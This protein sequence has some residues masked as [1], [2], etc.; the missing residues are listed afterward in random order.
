MTCISVMSALASNAAC[1]RRCISVISGPLRSL[2]LHRRAPI[3]TGAPRP[4][5]RP[6]PAVVPPLARRP[7]PRPP[8]C[9]PSLL[10]PCPPSRPPARP[11]PLRPVPS[12][13]PRPFLPLPARLGLDMSVKTKKRKTSGAPRRHAVGRDMAKPSDDAEDA[14]AEMRRADVRDFDL[15]P[16][17]AGHDARLRSDAPYRV[18]KALLHRPQAEAGPSRPSLPPIAGGQAAQS[19]AGR[20]LPPQCQARVFVVARPLDDSHERTPLFFPSSRDPTP[21]SYPGSRGPTPYSYFNDFPAR[22]TPRPTPGPA[23]SPVRRPA[24]PPRQENYPP[25]P[26]APPPADTRSPERKRRRMEG[27]DTQPTDVAQFLDLHA[28]DSD[29][30]DNEEAPFVMTQQ[31]L[32]QYPESVPL[33]SKRTLEQ[34]EVGDLEELAAHYEKE[35]SSYT[36]SAAMELDDV[37]ELSD[38]AHDLAQHPGLRPAMEEAISFVMPKPAVPALP[39]R[40]EETAGQ[41]IHRLKQLVLVQLPQGFQIVATGKPL[42]QAAYP[43]IYPTIEEVAPFFVV[44]D[45]FTNALFVG[46]A[47]CLQAGDRVIVTEGQRAGDHFYI[48]KVRDFLADTTAKDRYIPLE[49][50]LKETAIQA[51]LVVRMA[52]LHVRAQATKEN[53][54]FWHPLTQL[55]RHITGFHPSMDLGVAWIMSIQDIGDHKQLIKV[56]RENNQTLDV[57]LDALRRDFRLGDHLLVAHGEHKSRK[58]FVT[59]LLDCGLMFIQGSQPQWSEWAERHPDADSGVDFGIAHT[60]QVRSADVDFL[61]FKADGNDSAMFAVNNFAGQ[62]TATSEVPHPSIPRPVGDAPNVLLTW[63]ENEAVISA[64]EDARITASSLMG[65]SLAANF[66]HLDEE[67]QA[68]NVQIAKF[69]QQQDQEKIELLNKVGK[70]YEDLEVLVVGTKVMK[71]TIEGQ[72]GSV[73]KGKRGRVIGDFDSNARANMPAIGPGSLP[74]P[75][76][77]QAVQD[78]HGPAAQAPHTPTPE[79]LASA[80][81]AWGTSLV[82]REPVAILLA[83]EDN[84]TWL[85]TAAV[86]RRRVDVEILG[87]GAFARTNSLKT[88]DSLRQ[89]E[90]AKGIMLLGEKVAEKKLAKSKITLYRVGGAN[91][92]PRRIPG[93]CIKPL[94]VG[95][96]SRSIAEVAQRILVLGPD[97]EGNKAKVGRYAEMQPLVQHTY[98]DGVVGVRFYPERAGDVVETGFYQVLQ[99][100]RPTNESIE[101]PDHL[102]PHSAF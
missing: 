31:D 54:G 12:P 46:P 7:T 63:C 102:F 22:A 85:C 47:F 49:D 21:Y 77:S 18:P 29:D 50:V 13:P 76:V 83:G 84:G 82:P 27:P 9:P 90:G 28:S 16:I 25:H 71:A 1:T 65:H 66:Q 95:E 33:L 81:L 20:R 80:D 40:A 59:A 24:H 93:Q 68:R 48:L 79:P 4:P 15:P 70:R 86:V 96:D 64:Q 92:L 8:S 38:V 26:A 11:S 78:G 36:Q 69:K 37:V 10:P 39:P 19:S 58:G 99:L 100:C 62:Y 5:S 17:L 72:K 32:G 45:Q 42:R 23:T 55:R 52:R 61:P 57:E 6:S 75:L 87:V 14:E 35:A 97:V 44:Y 88:S 101:S 98:R 53:P 3:G 2:S 34:C 94:R 43:R 56:K 89:L 51:N 67:Q 41:M 73:F 74:A 60:F 91:G 30:N